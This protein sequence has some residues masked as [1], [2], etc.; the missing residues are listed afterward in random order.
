M[1][2]LIP[3]SGQ[4]QFFGEENHRNSIRSV[5]SVTEFIQKT[6]FFGAQNLREGKSVVTRSLA[7]A[8]VACIDSAYPHRE[9]EKDKPGSFAGQL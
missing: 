7:P 5:S 8:R 1:L 3:P 2:T 9:G 4:S 6:I